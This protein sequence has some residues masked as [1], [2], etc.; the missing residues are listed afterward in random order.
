MKT[1]IF[2]ASDVHGSERCFR[3]FVNAAKFY[4]AQALILGGDLTGKALI[5][6]VRQADGTYS[7][8]L[9][10]EKVVVKETELERWTSDLRNSGFY[11]FETTESELEELMADQRKIDSV[12]L[13]QMKAVLGSWVEMTD[14]RLRETD[15]KVYISPGNDDR[16]E[17]DECLRDTEHV[18]NPEGKVVEIAG[19]H[20]MITLG[21]TN[22]TPWHS[23]REVPEEKLGEMISNLA[24]LVVEMDKSI[25][26]LHVPPY[27]TEIDKAPAVSP[28]LKYERIGMGMLKM[29]STGSTAVRAAIEKYQPMLGF[30][31]HIHESRGFVKIGR[32]VCINPGSEY[33]KG[34]LSGAL[35]DVENGSL[36]EYILTTG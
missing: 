31:G 25:F 32:T 30:H 28:D 12:F 9:G 7:L 11:Y 26:N 35:V 24:D 6:I 15:V 23:P 13:E 33:G 5:P 8:S 34:M 19:D 16:F 10:G 21:Y 4:Q 20:E 3:K 1:R 36:N 2:F 14:K 18:V 22:R 27:D 17:I 29:I